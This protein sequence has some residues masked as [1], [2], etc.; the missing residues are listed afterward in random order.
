MRSQDAAQPTVIAIPLSVNWSDYE[1][2]ADPAH[3][4]P[5]HRPDQ[6]PLQNPEALI[7]FIADQAS[8][9]LALRLKAA[10]S[11]AAVEQ[12]MKAFIAAGNE[13]PKPGYESVDAVAFE[14][15]QARLGRVV[16]RGKANLAAGGAPFVLPS[17]AARLA[18]DECLLAVAVGPAET[19]VD[20]N[21]RTPNGAHGDLRGA[22]LAAVEICQNE[23]AQQNT[24]EALELRSKIGGD[25]RWGLYRT[26]TQPN[27][28]NVP[29][30]NIVKAPASPQP[31]VAIPGGA[32]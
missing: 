28:V 24:V 13:P 19:A 23:L 15:A 12:A 29:A 10:I 20:L 17:R 9:A 11:N 25:V 21:L 27:Q 7:P 18:P 32:Q 30:P 22:S 16:L 6:G 31:T 3:N 8:G 4:V 14:T 5:G 1:V 26:K 2:E